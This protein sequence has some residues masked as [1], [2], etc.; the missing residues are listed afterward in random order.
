MWEEHPE[1]QKTQARM[2]GIGLVLL[3]IVGLIYAVLSRDW[4]LL[5]EVCVFAAALLF[6]LA[7]LVGVVW[8]LVRMLRRGRQSRSR[9]NEGDT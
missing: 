7:L 4:D 9:F 5:R 2:I 8:L 3:F 1:Y 6:S